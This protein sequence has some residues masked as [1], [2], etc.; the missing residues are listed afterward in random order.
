MLAEHFD[1]LGNALFFLGFSILAIFPSSFPFFI[2][3]FVFLSSL[4]NLKIGK[5]VHFWG[6]ICPDG[7]IQDLVVYFHESL[8]GKTSSK[9][10]CWR[11]HWFLILL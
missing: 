2:C 6:V 11:L 4:W 10:N 8:L 9:L 1:V 7:N 3:F 5:Q